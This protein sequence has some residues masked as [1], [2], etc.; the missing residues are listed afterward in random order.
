[1]EEKCMKNGEICHF[2]ANSETGTS[3]LWSG[4]GT[5][6]AVAKRYRYRSQSVPILPFRTESILVPIRAVPIPMA[7][8]APVFVILRI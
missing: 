2:W 6:D 1:M 3:T 7:P 8:T 5:A 4:T